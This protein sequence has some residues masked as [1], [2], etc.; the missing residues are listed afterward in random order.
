MASLPKAI[1]GC[2]EAC[3]AISRLRH[4]DWP[5]ED[6]KGKPPERVREIRNDVKA[7]VE[8]LLREEGWGRPTGTADV[9]GIRPLGGDDLPAVLVLLERAGLPL[10]GVQENLDAFVVV[11]RDGDIVGCAGVERYGATGCSAA[12]RSTRGSGDEASLL[13]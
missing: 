9:T 2:G 7:G 10:V 12:S 8:R 3:P 11:Q 4:A 5:L 1:M 13:R 6:P